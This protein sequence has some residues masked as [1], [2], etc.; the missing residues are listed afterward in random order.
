MKLSWLLFHLGMTAILGALH[1]T[2][3]LG[4]LLA[5]SKSMICVFCCSAVVSA[6][7][8]SVSIVV[9]HVL[10]NVMGAWGVPKTL[11]P[12][13]LVA[14]GVPKVLFPVESLSNS[15]LMSA[16]PSLVL[17]TFVAFSAAA[18]GMSAVRSLFVAS[19]GKGV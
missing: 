2:A 4:V 7:R 18:P 6:Q 17:D 8:T 1:T 14:W 16:I 15:R 19:A 10:P 3:V 12:I 5:L 11:F 9:N 13:A